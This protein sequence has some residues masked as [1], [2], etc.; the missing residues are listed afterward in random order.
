MFDG[1]ERIGNLVRNQDPTSCVPLRTIVPPSIRLIAARR[2]KI[3]QVVLDLIAEVFHAQ[4]ADQAA[5]RPQNSS[6]RNG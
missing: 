2:G 1:L 6:R 5:L 3:G 4:T